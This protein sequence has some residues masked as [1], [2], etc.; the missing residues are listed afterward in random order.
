M[1]RRSFLVVLACE[2]L[3]GLYL[4]HQVES[5]EVEFPIVPFYVGIEECC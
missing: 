4:L 2:A 5:Y 1:I 3:L